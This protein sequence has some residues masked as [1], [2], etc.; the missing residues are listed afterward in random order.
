MKNG[1]DVGSSSVSD[2]GRAAM[3]GAIQAIKSVAEIHSP[4]RVMYDIGRYLMEGLKNGIEDGTI[5]IVRA[6]QSAM[7]EAIGAMKD[8][9]VISSPSK[10]TTMFGRYLSE[11]LANGINDGTSDAVT[12][13]KTMTNKVLNA[14]EPGTASFAGGGY[15]A[16]Y[17]TNVGGITLVVNGANVDNVDQL[18]DLVSDRLLTSLQTQ[19]R[20]YA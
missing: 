16:A 15:G 8:T 2:A 20:V 6:S 14:A 10:I 18:A 9:A 7:R 19:R 12:A 1:I 3:H 4:S 17:T 11:G 13:A 5:H